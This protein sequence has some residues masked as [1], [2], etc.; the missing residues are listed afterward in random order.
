MVPRAERKMLG[1]G[2]SDLRLEGH[3]ELSDSMR[4]WRL[5]EDVERSRRAIAWMVG[6]EERDVRVVR[7]W[8]PYDIV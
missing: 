4:G 1:V 2:E 6:W 7:M 3:I 5:A 8:E